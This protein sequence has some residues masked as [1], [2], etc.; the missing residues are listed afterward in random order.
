MEVTTV[1]GLD[2][3]PAG[4]R[5]ECTHIDRLAVQLASWPHLDTEV[6]LYPVDIQSQKAL[7]N[8][9]TPQ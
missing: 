7:R 2:P 4:L 3:V 6:T 9:C 1:P 5:N 8:A